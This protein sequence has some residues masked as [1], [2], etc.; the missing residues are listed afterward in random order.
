ML[1]VAAWWDAGAPVQFK[2]HIRN[3]KVGQ[4]PQYDAR[5]GLNKLVKLLKWPSYT[6]PSLFDVTGHATAAG[7]EDE[8]RAIASSSQREAWLN[9]ALAPAPAL[10][11]S[12]W[13]KP[14]GRNLTPPPTGRLEKQHL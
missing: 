1:T 3:I 13:D 14:T 11:S 9:E 4:N 7:M 8:E 10:Q 5:E 6:A 2:G 12:A